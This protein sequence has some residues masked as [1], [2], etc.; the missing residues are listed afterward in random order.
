MKKYL[1]MFTA[2]LAIIGTS[3][4][5]NA[6]DT[7]QVKLNNMPIE[8][9]AQPFIDNG[10][11][12]VPIRAITEAMNCEVE[13]DSVS[14]SA[15]IENEVEKVIIPI[16][17]ST[18]TVSDKT[19]S[20]NY[21]CTNKN[22]SI[23]TKAV[24]RDDRTY[25]PLRAL[26]ECFGAKVIWNGDNNTVD[27]TYTYPE[28]TT[29]DDAGVEYCA[30]QSIADN[31]DMRGIYTGPMTTEKVQEVTSV[32]SIAYN[33]AMDGYASMPEGLLIENLDDI[34]KLPNIE[35][36][37]LACYGDTDIDISPIAF[38]SKWK[39]VEFQ[40]TNIQDDAV[41]DEIDVSE[42]ISFPNLYIYY[43]FVDNYRSDVTKYKEA[44]SVYRETQDA[45][46]AALS[47]I[48]SDMTDYE[49]YKAL[50]DYMIENMDYDND[51]VEKLSSDV[52]DEGLYIGLVRGKGICWV[53]SYVYQELCNRIGLY[54]DNVGGEAKGIIYSADTPSWMGHDWNIVKIDGNYYHV[55]VTWDDPLPG[56]T[57]RYDYFLLSDDELKELNDHS[58]NKDDY[59]ECLYSY[60]S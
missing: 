39:S 37:G 22:V 36:I 47:V 58:W 30:R 44:L 52:T 33:H 21:K 31:N 11:T 25:V 59:P 32:C 5:V 60:K 38:K 6:N 23:D 2:I 19:E 51:A 48:K 53:Y 49:K 54:C 28:L 34:K 26:S 41:F 55:D 17:S 57:L 14:N 24:I 18:L 3:L 45:I 8:F 10:R 50:H 29:F 12:L 56:G 15:I 43:Y 9:D 16:Y 4:S 42:S 46:N 7:I 27:I 20:Y 40:D 35:N 1:F 13:W